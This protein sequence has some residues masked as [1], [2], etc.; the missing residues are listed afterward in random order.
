MRDM[1]EEGTRAHDAE[2]LGRFFRSSER[3]RGETDQGFLHGDDVL[4][5]DTRWDEVLLSIHEMPSDSFLE[6][7]K[8]RIREPGQLKNRVGVA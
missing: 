7:C 3:L 1:D 8:N 6:S 2:K 5:S 4:S